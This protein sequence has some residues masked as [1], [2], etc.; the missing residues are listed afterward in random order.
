MIM[1][2][3]LSVNGFFFFGMFLGLAEF[4]ASTFSKLD[5]LQT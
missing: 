1:Y 5:L 4:W 3:D 2:V